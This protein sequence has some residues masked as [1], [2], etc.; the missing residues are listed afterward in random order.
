MSHQ[1]DGVATSAGAHGTRRQRMGQ[2]VNED[3]QRQKMKAKYGRCDYR[4]LRLLRL[5]R[6]KKGK[7]KNGDWIY[8]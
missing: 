3:R 5:T 6:A 2:P 7:V 8:L 1:S 4:S